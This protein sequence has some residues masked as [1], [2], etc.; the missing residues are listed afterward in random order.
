M[1]KIVDHAQRRAQI[2]EALLAVAERDGHEGVTSRAVA[3]ELGVATGSLWHYF[4]NFDEVV[5]AA[6]VEVT[7]QTM[8]RIEAAAAGLRGLAM[9]E[10][11]MRQVLPL[12]ETTR[13]EAHVVVGFWGRLASGAPDSEQPTR[14]AWRDLLQT[15]VREAVEDGELV[16]GTP[17]DELVALLHSMSYGQQVMQVIES[18]PPEAHLRTLNACTRPWCTAR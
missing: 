10:A 18:T 9:L 14:I 3:R 4:R 13:R 11:I 8:A 1:P 16:A 6:A 7:S 2:V 15:A 17:Q 12:D 5:R